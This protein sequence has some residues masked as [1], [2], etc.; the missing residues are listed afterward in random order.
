M[1]GFTAN[2]MYQDTYRAHTIGAGYEYNGGEDFKNCEV[3]PYYI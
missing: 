2:K 3:W 1:K